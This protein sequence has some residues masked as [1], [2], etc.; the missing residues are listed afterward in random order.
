MEVDAM[1]IPISLINS[2]DLINGEKE[3]VVEKFCISNRKD[4]Q[5]CTC[6]ASA[7]VCKS[8]TPPHSLGAGTI[9][10]CSKSQQ[11]NIT[12]LSHIIGLVTVS[13]TQVSSSAK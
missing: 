10:V 7:R 1:S 12:H 13:E 3:E 8:D 9:V 2:T 4:K 11:G 5:F 6:S